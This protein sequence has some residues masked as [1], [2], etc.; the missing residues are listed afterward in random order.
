MACS[1]PPISTEMI[2][3]SRWPRSNVCSLAS[4]IPQ[5][6]GKV[7][8]SAFNKPCTLIRGCNRTPLHLGRL[9][10]CFWPT[11]IGPFPA[12]GGLTPGRTRYDGHRR[13]I[14]NHPS[15]VRREHRRDRREPAAPATATATAS[16]RAAVAEILAGL[17]SR[18]IGRIT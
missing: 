3:S 11:A 18:R 14:G 10:D 7:F 6:T 5:V 17:N 16:A 9:S 8:H 2:F 15:A 1:S 13:R 12:K 4:K